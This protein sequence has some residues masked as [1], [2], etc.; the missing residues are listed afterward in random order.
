[1]LIEFTIVRTVDLL[2]IEII[3]LRCIPTAWEWNS[4]WRRYRYIASL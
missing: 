4:P 2:P 3:T 1:L